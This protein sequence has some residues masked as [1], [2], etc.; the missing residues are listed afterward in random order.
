MGTDYSSTYNYSGNV[1]PDAAGGLLALMMGFGIVMLLL[2]VVIYVYM[3][4]CLM[5]IA[6]KTN[7]PNGWMAW[8][9]IANVILML[10]IAKKPAWWAA[11]LILFIIPIVNIIAGI[12][13]VIITIII[14][15]AIAQELRKPEWLGVLMIIPVA[16]LIVPG[17][18]AFSNGSAQTVPAAP[19]V[20]PAA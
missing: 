19:P 11:L 1:S 8:I 16:N 9:P 2:L 6:K 18:L 10:Q 4:I 20:Q 17:Y 5:K 3:A 7:T 13:W 15:M 14:W 12:A